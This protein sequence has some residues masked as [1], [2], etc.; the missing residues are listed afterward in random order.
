VLAL[1]TTQG[2]GD[3]RRLAGTVM[4]RFKLLQGEEEAYLARL[5]RRSQDPRVR[6]LADEVSKLRSTLA[7][8]V[9]RAPGTFDKA[10]QAMEASSWRSAR[11]AATTRTICAS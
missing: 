6:A 1:A 4:L 11:S 9:R 8:A 10:L 3:A 2:S 5:T 7:G